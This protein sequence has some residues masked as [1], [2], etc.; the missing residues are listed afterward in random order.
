[1]I[2]GLA[3]PILVV[4]L[5]GAA[6]YMTYRPIVLKLVVC[7]TLIILSL[8]TLHAQQ[9]NVD[10]LKRTLPQL[11]GDKKVTILIALATAQ[12]ILGVDSAISY[13]TQALQLAQQINNKESIITS[14]YALGILYARK[15]TDTLALQHLTH[16]LEIAK[17]AANSTLIAT[18]YIRLAEYYTITNAPRKS[19]EYLQ[20]SLTITE[21]K[22]FDELTAE[23]YLRLGNAFKT[24]SSYEESASY[25]LKAL[26]VYETL[27]KPGDVAK[28][29]NDL[30]TVYQRTDDYKDAL[31]CFNRASEINA[32]VHN[33]RGV[34][35]NT[36]NIGVIHQKKK[37]YDEALA[38]FQQA[39]PI[40]RTVNDRSAEAILTGNIGSTMV[41]QGK[42]AQGLDYLTKALA[43][44]ESLRNPNPKSIL[45]TLNDIADVKIK[46]KDG[47]GAKAVAER[48]IA[49]AG[50]Y[51]SPDYLR[52]GY[53]NL[54]KS[55]RL[56]KDHERAYTFLAKYNSLNDSLFGIEKAQQINELQ[57]QYNTEKKDMAIVS[58]QQ[59]KEISNAQREIY[60]LIA[61]MVLLVVAGLYISQRLKTQR[62]QQLLE[63]ER[64]IDRIKSDF[65][66]NISH[67]FR[68]PLALILGPIDTIL[69]KMEDPSARFQLWLMK[70][71]ATRLLRL[72]NQILELSKLQAGQ[73]KLSAAKLDVVNLI[74]GV[75]AS[76]Q[77]LA[78]SKDIE[79]EI[80][81]M[82]DDFAF[83]GDQDQIET[84][85][86]NLLSNAFKFSDAGGKIIVQVRTATSQ[87][88]TGELEMKVIDK[89][90]GISPK[91]LN[92]IFDRF[93]QTGSSSLKHFG[94]TG[95]GLAL[96]KDLVELHQGTIHVA[97]ELGVGT[98]VTVRLPLGKDHLHEDQIVHANAN[99]STESTASIEFATTPAPPV[100]AE[101]LE[102]E[103]AQKPIILLID[104]NEDVRNY[105]K[106]I[107]LPQ[108]ILFEAV[109]GE[110][111]VRQAFTFI[112]DLI[113]SDVMM[114]IMN[115]Y[116]V[117][118]M[119]KKDERTSHIP[120]ILLTAKASINSRLT[121]L[122]TEADMYLNKPF[123]PKELLLSI[124]N[125]IQSRKKLRDRYNRQ[126]IL[127]P[128][129]IAINSMDELFL[130]RLMKI[131]E[132]NY[133]D[134]NFSVEQ[135]SKEIGMSRSQ[136]HRKLHALTN[137]ST[138]QFI[139][140]FRLQRAMEFLKKN[141]G[142]I[143]EIAFKV[144]F[145][146][147]SYFN[148][149]FLQH[150]GCT[151]SSVVGEAL[152][153][154]SDTN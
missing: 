117:C 130:Q 106:S 99:V 140:S 24:L 48:V 37:N 9:I 41:E 143:S 56:L 26:R 134:E 3:A 137:E 36:L 86:I 14:E 113:I 91:H 15:K 109:N 95:I 2:K 136:L 126:V 40:A 153:S 63:K 114:P 123:V 100:D 53:L 85:C 122:E 125:L 118:R 78:D 147:P 42:F 66:A 67:E 92:N 59:E 25:Y 104:D 30:G 68:T 72:I 10:S 119:V 8:S 105:I 129:D 108:Y 28:V 4:R 27:G 152:A 116:D 13:A 93:Y 19:I 135:L 34:M 51:E 142:S 39:L 35:V 11:H 124:A 127:K 131:L 44:K 128:V 110:E 16:G 88:G 49:M 61:V 21:E 23:I 112:P 22:H 65:F 64:E 94:G 150:Y 43:L 32:S 77:S 90:V 133:E 101:I 83:Y 102:A 75:T 82:D 52:Y 29:Y 80:N 89:G 45:H 111:G 47:K 50:Q 31:D 38:F 103:E 46:L 1:M 98:E 18:G 132:E 55:Y 60:I 87:H 121:G 54:S 20:Q 5:L 79:L 138:S 58:L 76:F 57:I 33:T 81:C 62:N 84:I 71:N 7:C 146:N 97:S 6:K 120:V 115:G 148:K 69:S 96:T 144:G 74:K 70:K 107:L 17:D 141:S 154:D 73:L 149:V 151:P 12:D 145:S 139:R